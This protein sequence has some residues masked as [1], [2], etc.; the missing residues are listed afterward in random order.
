MVE[1]R[2]KIQGALTRSNTL[3]LTF[4]RLF[5]LPA[6]HNSVDFF[7]LL[8][9][10]SSSSKDRG[11]AG[12]NNREDC[13]IHVDKDGESCVIKIESVGHEKMLREVLE[14][15]QQLSSEVQRSTASGQEKQLLEAL[16]SISNKL[17]P[18]SEQLAEDQRQIQKKFD[19]IK[20]DVK[21]QQRSKGTL[22]KMLDK[23]DH[24]G[25]RK[26]ESMVPSVAF[27]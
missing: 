15:L 1:R 27:D 5:Q 2:E 11:T 22:E 7:S 13:Q 9:T 3:L 21:E 16:Q 17:K 8:S 6:K 26:L 25:R 4:F 23:V 12:S 24:L 18:L 19:E 14:R 20:Q 10:M